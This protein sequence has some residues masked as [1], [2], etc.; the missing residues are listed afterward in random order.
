MATINRPKITSIKSLLVDEI[1]NN[2]ANRIHPGIPSIRDNLPHDFGGVL[3][4]LK[5]LFERF[6]CAS[7]SESRS[8]LDACTS[9]I[10][11]LQ[12]VVDCEHKTVFQLEAMERSLPY[13]DICETMQLPSQLVKHR[14]SVQWAANRRNVRRWNEAVQLPISTAFFFVRSL[15]G[16]RIVAKSL[17]NYP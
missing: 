17:M 13:P 6:C 8:W 12:T 16:C 4:N 10:S 1:R 3:L 2:I 11:S 14:K 5:R 7:V 9:V 15:G